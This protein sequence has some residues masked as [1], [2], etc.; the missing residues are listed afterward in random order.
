MGAGVG[1]GAGAGAGTGTGTVG[2]KSDGNRRPSAKSGSVGREG[3]GTGFRGII[4]M[5]GRGALSRDGRGCGCGKGGRGGSRC[6]GRGAPSMRSQ[7]GDM[8]AGLSRG[9]C[10]ESVISCRKLTCLW[11]PLVGQ[12]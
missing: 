2:S 8:V 4:L 10:R 6:G 5:V 3:G 1:T 12:C 9:E 7:L 11:L